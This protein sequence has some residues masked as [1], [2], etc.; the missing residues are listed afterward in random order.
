M[1]QAEK[2][3]QSKIL[4]QVDAEWTG[5]DPFYQAIKA[6]QIVVFRSRSNGRHRRPR[7]RREVILLKADGGY[8]PFDPAHGPSFPADTLAEEI[9]GEILPPGADAFSVLSARIEEQIRSIR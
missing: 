7:P 1:S 3:Y 9:F 2:A 5:D 8:K 4:A 6:K